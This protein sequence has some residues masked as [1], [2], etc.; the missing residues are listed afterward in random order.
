[1]KSGIRGQQSTEK[2]KEYTKKNDIIMRAVTT[3]HK[4]IN[5]AT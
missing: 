2:G 3:L 5:K 4:S 1:M